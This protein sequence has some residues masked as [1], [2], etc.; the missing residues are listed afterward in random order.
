[1]KFV[2]SFGYAWKGIK[3][4]FRSQRNLRLQGLIAVVVCGLGFYFRIS[5]TEWCFVMLAIGLVL[6]LELINTCLE[7]L[8]DL[9]SPEKRLLAG[10]VKDIAAGAALVAA[11]A[12]ASVGIIIFGRHLA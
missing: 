3:T 4:A 1:M 7:A 6:A 10:N 9:V 2:R 8:T 5:A 11:L 12:S